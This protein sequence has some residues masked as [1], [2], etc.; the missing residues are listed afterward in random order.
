MPDTDALLAHADFVRGLAR[1]LVLDEAAADDIVQG[2][3]LAALDGRSRP[4]RRSAR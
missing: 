3:W 1:R 2:T 4:H